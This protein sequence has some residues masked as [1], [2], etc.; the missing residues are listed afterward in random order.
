MFLR[1]KKTK[2]HAY[3]QIVESY[4]EQGR[5]RQRVIGTIGRMEE[6]T[7]RGQVD[8][9]LRS[10]AKYSQRAILLLSGAN[11]PEAEVKKVGPGLIF[12]RLWEHIGIAE[13]I[14]ELLKGRRYRFEV[15]R[16]IFVTV[17]HRLMNPGS[18][19]QAERWHQAYRIDGV[20]R[21]S[22]Q[23]FYRAMAW[24]GE[25]L[26]ATNTCEGF[27]PRCVKDL[28]EERL[29]ERRR[30][31]FTGLDLVFFDTTSLYFEG[32]GGETIGQ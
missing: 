24:L 28:I 21:L 8:Q 19:R 29:F 22:L 32:D 12:G 26:K 30:D 27:S 2:N 11:D 18:D 1:V 15:E 10:L 13:H 4:R 20:D 5:V 31:L 6:L 17:L 23:Y 7:A 3:L 9:L 25:P 16:A 14:G